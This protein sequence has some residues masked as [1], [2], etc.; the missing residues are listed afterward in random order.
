[1]R[2]RSLEDLNPDEIDALVKSLPPHHSQ[3]IKR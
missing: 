1:L 2:G 3:K